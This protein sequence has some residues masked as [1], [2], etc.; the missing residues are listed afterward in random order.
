MYSMHVLSS[1]SLRNVSVV[2]LKD[3]PVAL[4]YVIPSLSPC[5]R[6]CCLSLA[7]G[8]APCLM[9]PCTTKNSMKRGLAGDASD[10]V[11]LSEGTNPMAPSSKK[12]CVANTKV[13]PLTFHSVSINTFSDGSHHQAQAPVAV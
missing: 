1:P 4:W 9:S 11:P 6:V 5:A 3:G 8:F 2:W 12:K 10:E 13:C 7:C